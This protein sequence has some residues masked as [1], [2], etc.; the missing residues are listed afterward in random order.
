VCQGGR[1]EDY[2]R[3][4]R[5]D[6][7]TRDI[8]C[9]SPDNLIGWTPSYSWSGEE[10]VFS[11]E[12]GSNIDLPRLSQVPAF[13]GPEATIPMSIWVADG[14]GGNARQLTSGEYMDV[15]PTFSPDGTRIA[16]ISKR[17]GV[18]K[19]WEMSSKQPSEPQLLEGDYGWAMRP[20]YSA[21][22]SEIFFHTGIHN[23]HTIVRYKRPDGT[24][25]PLP[26]DTLGNTHGS[27]TLRFKNAIL[28]HS[29]RGGKHSLW[30]FPL[31]G[32]APKE[33]R[34]SEIEIKAHATISNEGLLIFDS[35]SGR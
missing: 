10:N 35:P 29:S 14:D 24:I 4:L 32:T 17:T 5:I 33:I 26:N 23:R 22:G 28:A 1:F 15:R 20:W 34:I 11:C 16:F 7:A 9:I 13:Y 30:Q 21:D 27:F 3:I 18:W 12:T 31:D 19:L 2:Q 8:V 25:T 6:I